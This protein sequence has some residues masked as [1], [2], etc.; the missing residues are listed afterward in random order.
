MPLEVFASTLMRYLSNRFV[1]DL[2]DIPKLDNDKKSGL[3]GHYE[4]KKT[5]KLTEDNLDSAIV[6]HYSATGVTFFPQKSRDVS[7][8]EE[9]FHLTLQILRLM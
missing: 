8:G 7:S 2:R 1:T 3:I 6:E 9:C 4:V 5:A